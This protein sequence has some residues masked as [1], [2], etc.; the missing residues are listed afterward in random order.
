MINKGLKIQCFLIK[1]F[2]IVLIRG[3]AMETID[4]SINNPITPPWNHP[5]TLF[6]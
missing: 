4:K 2:T 6:E 5:E 1:Y 3:I